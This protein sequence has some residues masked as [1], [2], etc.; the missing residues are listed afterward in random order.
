MKRMGLIIGLALCVS[1]TGCGTKADA[2]FKNTFVKALNSRWDAEMALEENTKVD[3]IEEEKVILDNE[4]SLISK[5]RDQ[6]FND[7]ETKELF[8]KYLD[9]LEKQREL[10]KKDRDKE[11]EKLYNEYC[12]NEKEII[13]EMYN[14]HHFNFEKKLYDEFIEN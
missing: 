3:P 6:E 9:N 12:K 11:E 1:I 14:T 7:K 10:V 5:Y 4:H 13:K 2:S 8:L